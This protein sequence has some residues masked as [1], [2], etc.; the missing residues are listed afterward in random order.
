MEISKYAAW[1]RKCAEAARTTDPKLTKAQRRK[2][3][4]E[5]Q[6]EYRGLAALLDRVDN[7]RASST[8]G[9]ASTLDKQELM[10]GIC[11]V[12][13]V[14]APQVEYTDADLQ[15]MLKRRFASEGMTFGFALEAMKIG[16]KVARKSWAGFGNVYLWLLPESTI[17]REWVK[18]KMLAECFV[19]DELVCH[20][21]IRMKTANCKVLTG[22]VPDGDELLAE[23]WVI[24]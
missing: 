14:K 15:L 21:A 22:W 19:A 2:F 10:N 16:C 3:T 20:G 8:P 18:D 11:A 23:D 4:N 24:V 1:M 17:K 5:I 12:F 9:A 6:S 13:G 7:L